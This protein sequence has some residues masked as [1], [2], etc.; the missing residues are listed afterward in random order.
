MEPSREYRV[1]AVFTGKEESAYGEDTGSLRDKALQRASE[2]GADAVI[3]TVDVDNG[4]PIQIPS[5]IPGVAID[6]GTTTFETVAR[7]EVRMIVW[8]EPGPD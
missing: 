7:I 3:V 8:A 4:L 6:G 5:M 2:L 1:I